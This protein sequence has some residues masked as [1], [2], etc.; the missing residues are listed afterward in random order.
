MAKNPATAGAMA[1][2]RQREEEARARDAAKKPRPLATAEAPAEDAR[3][4]R[5]AR[6]DNAQ[7]V[8]LALRCLDDQRKACLEYEQI[9]SVLE[10]RFPG[11]KN[12]EMIVTTEGVA[13]RTVTNSYTLVEDRVDALRKALGMEFGTY[14]KVEKEHVV[15][16]DRIGPLIEKLG[17]DAKRFVHTTELLKLSTQ[18]TAWLRAESAEGDVARRRLDGYYVKK[19]KAK[20]SVKPVT[21]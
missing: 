20:I 6:M 3:L 4:R 8:A 15:P 17:V 14:V 10:G 18:A 11:E 21:S 2:A 1:P 7:L 12:A 19:S 16:E 9:C 13:E 5:L